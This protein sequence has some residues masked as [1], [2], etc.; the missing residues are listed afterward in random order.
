MQGPAKKGKKGGQ[1]SGSPKAQPPQV[2]PINFTNTSD[3]IQVSWPHRWAHMYDYIDTTTKTTKLPPQAVR[4]SDDN[5]L[6]EE[7]Y[8]E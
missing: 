3:A 5:E 2:E 8:S 6:D 4:D 7:V 1:S